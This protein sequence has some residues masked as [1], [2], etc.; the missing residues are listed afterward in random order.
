MSHEALS[1]FEHNI[2]N[3]S[4]YLTSNINFRETSLHG[5]ALYGQAYLGRIQS[6][7]MFHDFFIDRHYI[8]TTLHLV[9]NSHAKRNHKCSVLLPT[10]KFNPLVSAALSITETSIIR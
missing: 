5:V 2:K 6:S 10:R 9:L 8:N 7:L 1:T 3:F 4:L